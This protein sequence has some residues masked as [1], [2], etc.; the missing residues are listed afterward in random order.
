MNKRQVLIVPAAGLSSRFPNMRPKWL[1]THPNGKLMIENILEPFL[2]SKYE[3]ILTTTEKIYNDYDVELIIKQIFGNRVHVDTIPYQTLSSCETISYTLNNYLNKEDCEIII[4]DSDSL[5]IPTVSSLS[6][7]FCV[8]IDVSKI[9]DTDI[10]NKSFIKYDNNHI[11]TDI[12]EKKIFSNTI[13]VGLYGFESSL[14]FLKNYLEILN[15]SDGMELYVS[16]II[17]NMIIND[18]YFKY[19]E[20]SEFKDWGTL[21]SW[22][23]ENKNHIS[24][25]CDYDGVLVKNKGR[26]GKE[27][28][29]NSEDIPIISNIMSI[30]SKLNLGGVL[31]ITTC[32]PKKYENKIRE[33]LSRFDISVFQIIF[34]LPHSKRIL[35]NDYAP[36]NPYPTSISINVERNQNLENFLL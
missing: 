19:I 1:L 20:S 13:S 25:F 21:S 12:V 16:H 9:S 29:E 23:I 28:W 17:Y 36:T 35:I 6:G 2:Q 32:R 4:K 30:K 15:I 5:V 8:G 3:I 33:L 31:I 10:R 26:Y 11:I 34:D 27:N 14:S 24:I 18:S 22:N 7:N